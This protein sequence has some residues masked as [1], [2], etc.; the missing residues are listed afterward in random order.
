[1]ITLSASALAITLGYNIQ[2]YLP[3]T[4]R[5]E[6]NNPSQFHN[7]LVAV[8]VDKGPLFG[9]FA[10]ITGNDSH[11][12]KVFNGAWTLDSSETKDKNL[13]IGGV[14]YEWRD[15]RMFAGAGYLDHPD[16]IRLSGHTQFNLGVQYQIGGLLLGMEHYSN[17]RQIFGG[18]S[19]NVGID[20]VTL[21]YRF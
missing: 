13:L 11:E 12:A 7:A 20:F 9:K 4:E 18:T 14:H 1:M 19:P 21:G 6:F 3:W 5:Y 8:T 15:V 16:D 17:G 2:S 10:H